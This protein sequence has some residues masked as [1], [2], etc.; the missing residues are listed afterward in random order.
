[1][2][3]HLSDKEKVDL[4]AF[5]KTLTDPSLDRDQRTRTSLTSQYRQLPL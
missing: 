5:M 1:M 3:L 2:P 4:G